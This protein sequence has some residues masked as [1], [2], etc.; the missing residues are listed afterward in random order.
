MTILYL[1]QKPN[2]RDFPTGVLNPN[3]TC[4]LIG[5]GV[6]AALLEEKKPL[7]PCPLFILTEDLKARQIV[8]AQNTP[9]I[10]DVQWLHLILIHTKIV[11]F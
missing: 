5:D 10:D 9:I 2:W 7:L 1:W 11:S 6:F 8:L 4:V 3:D